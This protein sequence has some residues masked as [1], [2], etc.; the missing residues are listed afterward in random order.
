MIIRTNPLPSARKGM[1]ESRELDLAVRLFRK[2]KLITPCEIMS[3]SVPFVIRHCLDRQCFGEFACGKRFYRTRSAAHRQFDAGW[4][5]PRKLAPA[6]EAMNITPDDVQ[7]KVPFSWIDIQLIGRAV[8]RVAVSDGGALLGMARS[9][10]PDPTIDIALT[11]APLDDIALLGDLHCSLSNAA[12]ARLE[13]VE[14]TIRAVVRR[15][16]QACCG[17]VPSREFD[18]VTIPIDVWRDRI[19]T[20]INRYQLAVSAA[21]RLLGEITASKKFAKGW[22]GPWFVRRPTG[23][24]SFLR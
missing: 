10:V 13:E 4:I 8:R 20:A 2:H 6:L 15:A 1:S 12:T 19:V 17:F 9:S 11:L 18:T 22:L 5:P 7:T 23:H 14:S 21:L 3:L 24:C 16:R